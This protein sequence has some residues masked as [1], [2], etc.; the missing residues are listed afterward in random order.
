M[1]SDDTTNSVRF[2]NHETALRVFLDHSDWIGDLFSSSA[3]ASETGHGLVMNFDSFLRMYKML[4]VERRG[5]AVFQANWNKPGVEEKQRLV[6]EMDYGD[7]MKTAASSFT[8]DLQKWLPSEIN[9]RFMMLRIQTRVNQWRN[10]V[11]GKPLQLLGF[12]V[13]LRGAAAGEGEI[14]VRDAMPNDERLINHE[15]VAVW[16]SVERDEKNRPTNST[17]SF[18]FGGAGVAGAVA[19]AAKKSEDRL[20]KK[21]NATYNAYKEKV[22]AI[23]MWDGGL[24]EKAAET[25]TLKKELRAFIFM[26]TGDFPPNLRNKQLQEK[27]VAE[28]LAT[29]SVV[30]ME[31]DEPEGYQE[32]LMGSQ[33]QEEEEGGDDGDEGGSGDGGSGGGGDD[34]VE[35]AEEFLEGVASGSFDFDNDAFNEGV[36]AVAGAASGADAVVAVRRQSPRLHQ[37]QEVI[38]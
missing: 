21:K 13:V 25:I 23:D 2:V 10:V 37:G 33:V 27:I 36:A 19:A 29:S 8:S 14:W 1:V 24:R 28:K 4:T 31:E 7:M 9:L 32:W 17:A 5:G 30:P 11:V 26:K 6:G 18:L 35:N 38:H 12:D 22:G 34:A 16:P 15:V 20:L 3:D